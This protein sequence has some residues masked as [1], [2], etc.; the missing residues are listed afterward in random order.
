LTTD[1][2]PSYFIWL[3]VDPGNIDVNIHPTKTEIKFEDEQSIWQILNAT[4]KEALGKFNVGPSLDFN[5]ESAIEIPVLTKNTQIRMPTINVNP[6]FNP[7]DSD[8]EKPL[9]KQRSQ[10]YFKNKELS[11]WET[12]YSGFENKK[13]SQP[14]VNTENIFKD[15][16]ENL[17]TLNNFIQL[18]G[19][20]ILSPV[21]SGLM[22]IDQK[23]AHERILYE[24]Y[25]KVF[26][27]TIHITQQILFPQVIE[28]NATDYTILMEYLEIINQGGFDI[29]DFGNN[30]VVV[31]GCPA[32]ISAA[33][34]KEL[35]ERLLEELHQQPSKHSE[36]TKEY[37][38]M[39]LCK[40]S[41]I[42]Y[43]KTLSLEEIQD[44]ID[45]LFACSNHNF[46]PDGKPIISIIPMEEMEKRMK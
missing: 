37:L 44:L 5:T 28:L 14:E 19:K 16:I 42:P 11:N 39:L 22:I 8:N 41:A 17:N 1:A 31:N 2:I 29:R 9:N 35:V 43:G 34:P 21:R 12:L 20:Y 18:K 13:V 26:E 4:T 32:E 24:N 10:N 7:F 40:A 6:N 33:N 25:L 23:R 3:E 45:K 27:G 38:A 30:S 46:S 15:K 36:K